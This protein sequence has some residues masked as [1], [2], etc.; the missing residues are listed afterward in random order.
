MHIYV[1]N[2]ALKNLKKISR[3]KVLFFNN[4]QK[5]AK[6]ED[7]RRNNCIF[8]KEIAKNCT[9]Q[10][11]SR[12]DKKERKNGKIG[13][14]Y[15][16]NLIENRA[17]QKINCEKCVNFADFRRIKRIF[18]QT[19]AKKGSSFADFRRNKH[20]FTQRIAKKAR[21]L[22]IFGDIIANIHN[23]KQKKIVLQKISV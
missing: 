15:A 4:G 20:I 12:R 18:T 6:F 10:N 1:T 23:Q 22:P 2:H 11:I 3:E 8:T 21:D 14:I 17:L 5:N 13:A 16:V 19:I 9:F 7:F